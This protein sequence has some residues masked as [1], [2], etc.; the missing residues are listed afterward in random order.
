MGIDRVSGG[1]T[2]NG[3]LLTFLNALRLAKWRS[4]LSHLGWLYARR[5]WLARASTVGK[6]LSH[7]L[8]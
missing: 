8:Q 5:R 7:K 6:C 2:G 4:H 1:K 3:R